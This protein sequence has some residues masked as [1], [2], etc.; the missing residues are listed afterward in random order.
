M[1]Q[2]SCV[3]QVVLPFPPSDKIGI[4]SVQRESEEIIPMKQM[5]MDWIPYM[6]S[7][8]AALKHLKLEQLKKYEYCFTEATP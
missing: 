7:E 4:T 8:E 1:L 5:K 2:P 6:P 3:K